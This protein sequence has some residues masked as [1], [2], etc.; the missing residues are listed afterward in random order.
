MV[1][2]RHIGIAAVILGLLI[3]SPLATAREPNEPA[4]R[5]IKDDG[6]MQVREYEP[7][8]MAQAEAGGDFNGALYSG[9]MRLFNYISGKNTGRSKI[10]MT[11][12]VTEE[13]AATSEKIPMTAPVTSERSG[14]NYVV[15]FIMP[16][17]Y[18]LETLPVPDD[19]SIT[20]RQV[21]AH[22]AA[23]IRFSGRMNAELADKKT[24]ELNEWMAK[25]GLKPAGD[26]LLAQYNPPWIPGFMRRN[27]VIV[28]I[29]NAP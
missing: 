1:Y 5:V 18:T 27:E 2:F 21:P 7:Y 28:S 20:F 24:R 3:F 23:S 16:A 19:K 13:Q 14:N 29:E 22:R 11:V 9:F 15:S 17:N 4:Y 10:R 8:I 12:P 26:Y 6:N 25:S